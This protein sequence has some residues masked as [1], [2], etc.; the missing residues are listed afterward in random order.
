MSVI[1]LI[2]QAN[3]TEM[4]QATTQPIVG[5]V[6]FACR[7]CKYLQVPKP[8]EKQTKILTLENICFYKDEIQLPQLQTLELVTADHISITF[9]SQK[10]CRKNDTITQLRTNNKVLCPVIQWANFSIVSPTTLARRRRHQCPP[11]GYAIN[12]CM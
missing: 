8:E 1:S 11:S 5:A 2:A 10:N 12:F 9:I 7:S 6:F 3:M 4:Q